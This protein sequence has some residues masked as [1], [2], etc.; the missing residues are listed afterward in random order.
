MTLEYE[1]KILDT[2]TSPLNMCCEGTVFVV[3]VWM[4]MNTTDVS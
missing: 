4:F 1:T 2:Q 3:C